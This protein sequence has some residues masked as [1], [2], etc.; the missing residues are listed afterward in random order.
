[1]FNT[2][3]RITGTILCGVLFVLPAVS[4]AAPSGKW[5][6]GYYGSYFWDVP[7]Y[8]RPEAVDMT[9]MTHF[10][11]AR[12]GPGGGQSGGNPGQIMLGGGTAQSNPQVGPGAP[13]KTVEDY[14][15]AR[16][17][18]AGIKAL[19]ML[20]GAGDAYGFRV[21]T[22]PA[23]RPVFVK[24]LVD[25]IVAHDYDGIDV[26][27]EGHFDSSDQLALEALIKE[28][29]AAANARPRYKDRPVI[30][31]FPA[32]MLNM[33]IDTV[34]PHLVRVA[35][36]VDQFNIMSYATAWFGSGWQSS[37]FAGITGNT[38]SRPMD[39]ASTIQ[40]YV[41]AGIPRSKIGMGLGFYGMNYKPPFTHPGQVTDGYDSSYWDSNDVTWNYAQLH[42]HGYLNNG[43]YVWDAATQTS[44][45]TYPG[46]YSV[47]GRPAAGYISYE[48]PA[49][50]AAKGAWTLSTNPGEG[51]GGTIIW[52]VNYGTTNGVNNP[53]LAAV[54][55]AFLDPNAPE[56]GPDP[57]P[58]PP[59]P[60]A[61]ISTTIVP[62]NDWGSGYCATL[63]VTNNSATPGE[64][65]VSV[66][67]ADTI[68]SLWNGDYQIGAGKLTVH[69][70]AW[71]RV[72]YQGQPRDVGFCASRP[73]APAPTPTPT[74]APTPAALTAAVI[75]KDDWT[76][77]YC[78]T[79][80]VTNSS[81]TA[82]SKW[83]VNLP[84]QGQVTSLWNGQ[85]KPGVESI[86]LSGPSWNPDLAAGAKVSDI[87][88]CATR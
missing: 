18:A 32:G 88:F 50:I 16:A 9:A 3:R 46:G 55:K 30:I 33:N 25:Y 61:D 29:R 10:V 51:A 41:N 52:L 4:G 5:V 63:R 7:D 35:G 48:D 84:L 24:N 22:T 58:P 62:G 86:V 2:L 8:Q 82:A 80:T 12:I 47:S 60:P 54:K 40:A 21:S 15:V 77:G 37:V 26:D 64:W 83:S 65:N 68:T 74:P 23:V 69:G 42:K 44:Y 79:V 53:L 28:L 38:P 76:T 45:R 87:G 71:N 14:M 78:A 66:P 67:F 13:T 43:T 73:P 81:T 70:L 85:Y 72:V 57:E 31:T 59:P 49:S 56:P 11:F 17:H 19:I 1:M 39:I 20:G 34:S 27:W 75:I 36:L 6:T